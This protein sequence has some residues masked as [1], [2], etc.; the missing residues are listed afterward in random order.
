MTFQDNGTMNRDSIFGWI[1]RFSNGLETH[2]CQC[3]SMNQRSIPSQT[4]TKHQMR[5]SC[6]NPTV[7]KA[8]SHVHLLLLKRRCYFV[9][10]LAKF[11]I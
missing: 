2:F 5:L 11:V 10:F 9:L 3:L 7:L 4:K 1:L 8:P 6:T